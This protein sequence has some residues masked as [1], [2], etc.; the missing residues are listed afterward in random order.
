MYSKSSPHSIRDLFNQIAAR[1]D[2]ANAVLSFLL[3]KPWNRSL[4]QKVLKRS[5]PSIFIDLCSG[6]GEIALG[7]LKKASHP[8]QAYLV[9]FSSKML[10][11]AKQK[12]NRLPRHSHQLSYLEGDVQHLP[13]PDQF[14]DCATLAYGIRNVQNPA[15]CLREAFRV[16][17][18]GGCLGILELTRPRSRILR[19]GHTLYL[20]SCL[21]FIGKWL[22]NNQEAYQYLCRSI[23]TFIAPEELQQLLLTEGFSSIERYSL[24][25]GIATL[26]IGYKPPSPL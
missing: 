3:Y 22:T 4:I 1:Y 20:K 9:D 6:T 7:Y 16:L 5:S 13:F 26:L 10:E 14:V 2:L 23:Q 11:Q 8:C 19:L 17:K 12:A 24:A 21:P 18:P 25:G 15:Q